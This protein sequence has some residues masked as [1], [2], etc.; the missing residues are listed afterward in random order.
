[1]MVCDQ[2]DSFG[3]MMPSQEMVESI[4]DGIYEDVCRMHPD[5]AEYVRDCEM[6][7]KDDPSELDQFGHDFRFRRHFRR[8]GLFRDLID[9]LLLS[10]M[11][12]RRRRFFY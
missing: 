6:K 8:R 7:A 2:M 3:N 1:M 10:E 12:R 4:T 5:I 11:G 9:I